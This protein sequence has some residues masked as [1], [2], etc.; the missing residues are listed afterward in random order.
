MT[1]ANSAVVSASPFGRSRNRSAVPG[2]MRTTARAAA[3]RR[4]CG[5]APTSTMRTR[6]VPS[7]TCESS[8]MAGRLSLPGP[9]AHRHGQSL[10]AAQDRE[11]DGLP[12]AQVLRDD[13]RHILAG[14]NRLAR[15]REDH[16]APGIHGLAVDLALG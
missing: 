5:F 3:R 2:A 4:D 1:P 7:S 10:A 8:S 15:D 16:I 13:P 9:E 11:A 6:P 12:R 14:V